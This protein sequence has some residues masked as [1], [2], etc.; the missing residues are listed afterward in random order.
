M[1]DDIISKEVRQHCLQFNNI[2]LTAVSNDHY[3]RPRLLRRRPGPQL[4]RFIA[5]ID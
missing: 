3:V 1:P 5:N 4:Y 2:L